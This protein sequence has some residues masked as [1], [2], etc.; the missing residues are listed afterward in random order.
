MWEVEKFT[1]WSARQ[2]SLKSVFVLM[3]VVC[4]VSSLTV[5][6]VTYA[7]VSNGNKS[8]T[9]LD[10]QIFPSEEVKLGVGEHQTFVAVVSGEP[11]PP[12]TYTWKVDGEAVGTGQSLEFW[13]EESTDHI[14]LSVE[15]VD[16]KE[17]LGY[18]SKVVYDPFTARD[19]YLQDIPSPADFVIDTDGSYYWATRD[20]GYIASNSTSGLTVLQACV[21]N[22]TSYGSIYIKPPF[23]ADGQVTVTTNYTSIVADGKPK[24]YDSGEVRIR[25]IKLDATDGEL[26]GFYMAGIA[27]RELHYFANDTNR[28]TESVVERC[29][30]YKTSTYHGIIFEGDGTSDGFIDSIMIRDSVLT[31]SGEDGDTWGLVTYKGVKYL[32]QVTF[33][34]CNFRGYGSDQTYFLI[35]GAADNDWTLVHNCKFFH[36]GGSSGIAIFRQ[37]TPTQNDYG[38]SNNVRFMDN[39]VEAHDPLTWFVID[40]KG[41]YWRTEFDY[42]IHNN[43]LAGSETPVIINCTTSDLGSDKAKLEFVGNSGRD[44][45]SLGDL[46][47][48]NS[49]SSTFVS[50]NECYMIGEISNPVSGSYITDEG[51]AGIADNTTYTNHLSTKM[52]VMQDGGTFDV[53]VDG[54]LALDDVNQGTVIVSTGQTYRIDH[55]GA[56]TSLRVYGLR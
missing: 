4:I 22:F 31:H 40:A 51:N 45:T 20:D 3:L 35:D 28:I 46:P 14:I 1:S 42:K 30:I 10:V 26:R 12:I 43:R 5:A 47:A 32:T 7:F 44:I 50:G 33:E 39:T 17:S 37:L 55:D 34:S 9:F 56:M 27:T 54:S 36:M 13:F 6:G 11:E 18:A 19:I 38:C 49:L 8:Q 2:Y 24:D 16:S 41:S 23:V 25:Q 53:Y 15:V 48:H 21:D 52:I 29:A